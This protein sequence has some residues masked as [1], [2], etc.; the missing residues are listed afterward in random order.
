MQWR[1]KRYPIGFL[2]RQCTAWRSPLNHFHSFKIVTH[3]QSGV[4]EPYYYNRAVENR[5]ERG[6]SSVG[7]GAMWLRW[8]LA[9]KQGQSLLLLPPR[10][11][12]PVMVCVHEKKDWHSL[13][14]LSLW[15]NCTGFAMHSYHNWLSLRAF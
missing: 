13:A 1:K 3:E 15:L 2:K 8:A 6:S 5:E 14:W 11:Q 4:T 7:D 9:N 12:R 10:P